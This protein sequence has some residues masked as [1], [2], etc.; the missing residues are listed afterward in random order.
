MD[1]F[2]KVV[3]Y[4]FSPL[5]QVHNKH[6]TLLGAPALMLVAIINNPTLN[7]QYINIIFDSLLPNKTIYEHRFNLLVPHVRSLGKQATM[8]QEKKRFYHYFP[9]PMARIEAVGMEAM[10]AFAY[11]YYLVALVFF[12]CTTLFNS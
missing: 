7:F 12:V 3:A 9:C 2:V 1:I 10:G 11:F 6:I 8:W 4:F 5:L